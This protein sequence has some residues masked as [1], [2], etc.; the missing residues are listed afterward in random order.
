MLVFPI[1]NIYYGLIDSILVESEWNQLD[2]R[3]RI[4]KGIWGKCCEKGPNCKKI[5]F[6]NNEYSGSNDQI[7]IYFT[8]EKIFH[9]IFNLVP[10]CSIHPIYLWKDKY[11]IEVDYYKFSEVVLKNKIHKPLKYGRCIIKFKR[12]PKIFVLFSGCYECSLMNVFFLDF[13]LPVLCYQVK[14]WKPLGISH[15]IK[16]Y[17][18]IRYQ[19]YILYHNLI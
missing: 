14:V 10:F 1:L 6:W 8:Y 11:V 3:N 15:L 2:Y 9:K 18:L 13:H 16:Y 17:L 5:F 7:Y 19:S 12:Y 4:S